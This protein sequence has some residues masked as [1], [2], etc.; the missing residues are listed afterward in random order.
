[1]QNDSKESSTSVL[2]K[3]S[4]WYTFSGF[5]TRALGFI[6]IPLFTRILSKEQI[7]NFT[8]YTVWQSIL[9]IVCGMEVYN[10]INRARFDFPEENQFN[11]YISSCLV[12]SF[13]IT[14][15]FLGL[16][17]LFQNI[18]N[19]VL[20]IDNKY[21]AIMI[22]YLFTAPAFSMFQMK[23]RILYRYKLSASITFFLVFFSSALAVILVRV[24]SSDRLFGR[25]FGQYILYI[26]V[27]LICTI[28]FFKK[29]FSV[30]KAYLSYAI[31]LGL[32]LV[33]NYLGSSLLLSS[34]SLVVKH[35]CSSV[36]VSYLSIVHSVASIIILLVQMLNS[37]WAPWFYDKLKA[38]QLDLIRKTLKAYVYVV[39]LGTMGVLLFAPEVIL[40]LG[41]KQY[42]E[43]VY[44]LPANILNG[45]FTMLVSQMV[46]LEIYYKKTKY[47]AI[48]TG[49]IAISN[50]LLNIC[51]VSLWDYRA[52]CYVTVVCQ[53][54]TVLLH[55]WFSRKMG[56]REI[57]KPIDL[58][59]FII[60]CVMLIPMSLLL[61][62][63]TSIRVVC[64]VVFALSTIV[65]AFL[66]R[67]KVNSF[68]QR[69]R[70]K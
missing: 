42:S 35:M 36:E 63:R 59:I 7:G 67:N 37:A 19:S 60:I 39:I 22:L 61:Y 26:I 58:L 64:I 46:N 10:T 43:A 53:I 17:L 48:I 24:F 68:I 34:D 40:L 57:I 49:A 41:G 18:I 66:N 2:V 55:Y 12:L 27:G 1:M 21:M 38:N 33:L 20:L 30:K 23:Q 15:A 31:R 32:P 16:Y 70:G 69:F 52:V 6:T 11:S 28:H 62:L 50:I 3:S 13:L 56:I 51:G 65:A 8:N 54:T 25:I 29:S 44:I 4:F 45:V 14:T 5:F 9:V 47:A